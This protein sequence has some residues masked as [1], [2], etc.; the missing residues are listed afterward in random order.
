MIYTLISAFSIFLIGVVTGI[1][2]M[3]A[4]IKETRW[5][6]TGQRPV[7]KAPKPDPKNANKPRDPY[8]QAQYGK[9]DDGRSRR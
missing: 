8:F 6:I 7:T 2:C 5:V 1:C 4:A 3:L 9:P